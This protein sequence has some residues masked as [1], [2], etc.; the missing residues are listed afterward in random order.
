MVKISIVVAIYNVEKYLKQCIQSIIE[1]EYA[2]IEVILVNDGSTDGSLT[3]C[4][5]FQEKDTRIKIINQQHS[6][7][8]VARNNGLNR[9][10]GDWI[11]FVDGDD[12][13]DSKII[14]AVLDLLVQENDL[15][16]FSNRKIWK[17]RIITITHRSKY[18]DI[19]GKQ[20]F[21][22]MQLATLNRFSNCKYNTKVLDS[23][24]IWNKLY[25]KDFLDKNNLRFVPD[26]PKLQD[27]TFNLMVYEHA[28]KAVFRDYPGYCYRINQESVTRRYQQDVIDKF[29]YINNW[30][31][32]FIEKKDE[33]YLNAYGA[34]LVNHLRTCVVL[35]LCN[36][37]NRNSYI[38][39]DG[40]YDLTP[41]LFP[42]T[43]MGKA[44]EFMLGIK[45]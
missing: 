20:A 21:V 37:E 5:I 14:T 23:V 26:M 17:Q 16:I 15:V 35:Y 1:Q 7:A 43:E 8:N 24:S 34:R 27:L 30:I 25:R 31:K 41:D 29:V 12:F 9:A 45:E 42:I 4:E 32:K 44:V 3:I 13:V 22:Q 6:G 28:N 19:E 18:L 33:R 38:L 36:K 11:L 10:I 2:Y 40:S 39:P